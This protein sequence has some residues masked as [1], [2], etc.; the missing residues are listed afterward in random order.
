MPERPQRVTIPA[1]KPDTGRFSVIIR[2]GEMN[3]S[4]LVPM[5]P[6]VI[7]LLA[8]LPFLAAS[9]SQFLPNPDFETW[10]DQEVICFSPDSIFT[11]ISWYP[12][13]DL[14]AWCF[15]FDSDFN[16]FQSTTA[17]SGS[18]SVELRPDSVNNYADVVAYLPADDRPI[19]L[20][21]WYQMHSNPGDTLR[22][23]FALT[24]STA[25]LP[26]G[27]KDTFLTQAQTS[28]TQFRVPLDYFHPTHVADS[29]IVLVGYS[30]N[31]W[32]QGNVVLVD[33]LELEYASTTVA[34]PGSHFLHIYPNP[35]TDYFFVSGGD[36]TAEL[37]VFNS[38]GQLMEVLTLSPRAVHRVS[39]AGWSEGVYMATSQG[40]GL[41]IIIGSGYAH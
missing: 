36:E 3:R 9:Q 37:R 31:S 34:E 14:F 29:C 21:G 7:S 30:A 12:L 5:K 28:W 22:L 6:M 33:N 16:L 11:P 13:G 17:H 23:L 18:Y 15:G 32:Q 26:T 25:G 27:Y 8:S 10:G 2:I 41:K 39:I 40:V 20:T 35:A 38:L 4:T 19:A 1:K 24:D